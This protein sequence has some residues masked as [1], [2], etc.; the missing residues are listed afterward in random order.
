MADTALNTLFAPLS[1]QYCIWFYWLSVLG[2]VMLAMVL[3]GAFVHLFSKKMD[4]RFFYAA[5]SAAIAY[6]IF[7]FQNRLLYSMCSGKI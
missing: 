1:R 2:F 3:L 4:A 5:F 6:L 7:Y